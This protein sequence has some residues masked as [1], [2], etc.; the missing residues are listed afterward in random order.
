MHWM[1][2]MDGCMV[3][4]GVVVRQILPILI[5]LRQQRLVA[6]GIEITFLVST[7]PVPKLFLQPCPVALLS[8]HRRNPQHLPWEQV[9]M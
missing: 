2:I 4:A 7:Q 1:L 9:P 3:T 5:A 8:Y 6:G